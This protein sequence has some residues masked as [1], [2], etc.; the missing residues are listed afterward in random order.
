MTNVKLLKLTIEFR[1][2]DTEFDE[3]F[4]RETFGNPGKSGT[5]KS[6]YIKTK[7]LMDQLFL[8]KSDSWASLRIMMQKLG[9]AQGWMGGCLNMTMLNPTDGNNAITMSPVKPAQA[10]EKVRDGY[11]YNDE[12]HPNG[13]LLFQKA[14]IEYHPRTKPAEQKRPLYYLEPDNFQTEDDTKGVLIIGFATVI[15]DQ[16]HTLINTGNS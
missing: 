9:N 12:T 14:G 6:L 13:R 8:E 4:Y 1:N 7:S 5:W 3:G 2:P 15:L 11:C 16:D 10:K